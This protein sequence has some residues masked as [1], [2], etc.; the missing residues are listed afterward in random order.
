MCDYSTRAKCQ[1]KGVVGQNMIFKDCAFRKPDDNETAVCMDVGTE[2]AFDVPISLIQCKMIGPCEYNTMGRAEMDT[3]ATV[4]KF[5]IGHEQSWY[6][7]L[8][9][10]GQAEDYFCILHCLPDGLTAKIVTLP[11]SATGHR[12]SETPV[13]RTARQIETVMTV[14]L[15]IGAFIGLGLMV[16]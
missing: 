1:E 3:V 14:A 15:V 7:T 16:S 5:S 12:S 8:R 6:D 10:A 4:G 13:M 11:Q 2:I 9:F